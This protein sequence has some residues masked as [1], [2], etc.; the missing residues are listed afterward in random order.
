MV[1]LVTLRPADPSRQP[2]RVHLVG[3]LRGWLCEY[4]T[5]TCFRS[6]LSDCFLQK[7]ALLD[8]AQHIEMSMWL[9]L[10]LMDEGGNTKD[11]LTLPKGTDDADKL[12]DQIKKDFDDGKELVV[13]VL[14]VSHCPCSPWPS[15][16]L[17]SEM[18]RMHFIKPLRVPNTS[19]CSVRCISHALV[20]CVAQAMGEE[21][22]SAVKAAAGSA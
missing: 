12:A 21:M 6:A 22:V 16:Q 17:A 20:L 4:S 19:P 7:L 15:L 18:S 2:S 1:S 3:C 10:S 14:K 8:Y 9:Q 5:Y 11:D 13:T